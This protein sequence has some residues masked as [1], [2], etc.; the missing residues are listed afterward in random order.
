MH[1]HEVSI[2]IP[3]LDTLMLIGMYSLALCEL[4]L[5]TAA[6]AFRVLPRLKLYDTTYEDIR[7]DFDAVT[8]QP[9]KGTRGVGV[10]GN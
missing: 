4:Y 1:W 9:E 6:L 8:P 10:R 5:A 2:R 7:Y 3:L